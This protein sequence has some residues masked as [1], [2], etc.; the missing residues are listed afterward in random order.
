MHTRR[1]IKDLICIYPAIKVVSL[2]VLPSSSC[3]HPLLLFLHYLS[4]TILY[5]RLLICLYVTNA[6]SSLSPPFPYPLYITFPSFFHFLPCL[7]LLHH[8]PPLPFSFLPLLLFTLPSFRFLHPSFS[9]SKFLKGGISLGG[10]SNV[11]SP[12]IH[13]RKR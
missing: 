8:L 13:G 7:T 1:K 4:Y 11:V 3:F 6:P 9:Y 2:P 10:E 5:P 12:K